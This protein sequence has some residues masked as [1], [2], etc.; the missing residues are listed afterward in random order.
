MTGLDRLPHPIDLDLSASLSDDTEGDRLKLPS[1][2]GTHRVAHVVLCWRAHYVRVDDA[3]FDA[4]A[5]AR[6]ITCS[7]WCSCRN[8]ACCSRHTDVFSF[9]HEPVRT[10]G[11]YVDASRFATTPS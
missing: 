6:A 4:A 2:R 8:G 11:R 9:S 3:S 10:P 7:R 5:S 1:K